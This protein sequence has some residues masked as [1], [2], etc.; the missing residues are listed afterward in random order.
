MIASPGWREVSPADPLRDG[1]L[2]QQ[3]LQLGAGGVAAQPRDTRQEGEPHH[4]TR[5]L[6][7]SNYSTT[8]PRLVLLIITLLVTRMT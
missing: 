3:V 7:V 4:H 8:I 6:Q 2:C 1:E 5:R